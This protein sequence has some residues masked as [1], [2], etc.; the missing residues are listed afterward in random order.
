MDNQKISK[1]NIASF[2]KKIEYVK[3]DFYLLDSTLAENIAFGESLKEIDPLKLNKVIKLSMLSDLVKSLDRGVNTSIG[4][5]GAKS[6]W[7]S[8]TKNCYCQS[9]I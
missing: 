3:Q 9:I 7:R 6:F 8:K 1:I 5:F 4:E 2:R